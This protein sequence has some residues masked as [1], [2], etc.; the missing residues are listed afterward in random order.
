[1][2]RHGTVNLSSIAA[3]EGMPL[4]PDYL[5]T[6]KE[7]L[8]AKDIAE[9]ADSFREEAALMCYEAMDKLEESKRLAAE[10]N[11]KL[12]E[13]RSMENE[14]ERLTNTSAQ[15]MSRRMGL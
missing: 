5:L 13:A 6:V 15:T 12:A 14:A 1:M 2:A 8:V 3:L 4:N 10:G 9:S 11:A 7:R